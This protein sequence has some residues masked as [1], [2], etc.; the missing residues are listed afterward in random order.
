M[1]DKP[2]ISLFLLG[3]TISMAPAKD[4]TS[5][6]VV[7]SISAEDLCAAV[8]GLDQLA[9]IRT[10]TAKMVASANLT[11]KDA[12]LLS[13]EI[14]KLSEKKESDGIVIVQGTDTLEEMAFLLDL[15]TDVNIP[16]VLTGA[17]RSAN[18]VSADGPGNILSSVIAAKYRPIADVGVVVLM[19]DDIHAARYVQKCHTRDLAAFKSR[20][21]NKVGQIC[22]G[23]VRQNYTPT[24]KPK[25]KLS[26]TEGFPKVGLIKATFGD[27]GELLKLISGAGFQG[28]V[29]EAFGAGH[30][31]ESWLEL[32]T[33]LVKKMPVML[34][35]RAAEGPVFQKTYGYAGAEID[36]IAR[37]LIPSGVLDGPKARL[38]MQVC[39]M[40]GVKVTIPKY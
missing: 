24:Q 5:S 31:P 37:G 6:G 1:A 2:V 13:S 29:I 12:V 33:E 26:K 28:I 36:L 30:L 7:P 4:A 18:M 27:E 40:S 22:E 8:P 16:I 32:L 3:G 39:L 17:M 25:F 38:Y 23:E 20:N 19:N 9:E 10:H 34:C 15:I 14:E 21:G 11:I 35:S